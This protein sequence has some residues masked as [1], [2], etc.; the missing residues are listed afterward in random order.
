MTKTT[1]LPYTSVLQDDKITFH[2]VPREDQPLPSPLSLTRIKQKLSRLC[3]KFV[4]GGTVK[5]RLH[6]F[7]LEQR[8]VGTTVSTETCTDRSGGK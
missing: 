5:T 1:A 4:D 6:S 7:F 8:R 2:T 3:T